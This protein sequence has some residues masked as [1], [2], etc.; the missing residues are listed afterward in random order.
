MEN[1]GINLDVVALNTFGQ[2]V[3][4]DLIRLTENII[5]M[6]GV[7]FNIDSPDNWEILFD[8]LKISAKAKK[9]KSGQYATSED[10]LL[11]HRKDHAIVESIL[12]YRQL[13]KL[14]ST[15][16]DPLPEL[17]DLQ[18]DVYIPTSCKQ[19]PRLAA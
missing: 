1:E 12:E 14:K 11:K 3:E 15:Y 18:T 17:C 2:S 4:K 19:L 7:E 16:I 9:T 13:K 8:K 6:A 5:K 10:V